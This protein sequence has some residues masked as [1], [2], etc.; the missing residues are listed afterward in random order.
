M[1]S[2]AEKF[3][4]ESQRLQNEVYQNNRDTLRKLGPLIGKS[5]A[6][7]GILHTFGSGHSEIISREIIGRAGG[8]VCIGGIPDPTAGA[9]ENLPGYGEAIAIRYARHFGM[10]KGE[11][12]IV[13]SNSGKNC[14]PIEV[15]LESKKRGLSVVAVTCLEMARQVQTQHPSGKKLHEVADFTLDN[16]GVSGDA[17]IPVPGADVKAG[18]TSTLGGALLMNLLHMEIVDY[19]ATEKQPLPLLQ[20]QNT[21]GGMERNLELARKYNKRLSKPL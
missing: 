1:S 16:G 9:V 11:F 7:G 6:A 18:P 17:M 8:L 21:E 14:S 12:I 19:L 4:T 3:F 10:E 5:I 15:A 2:L 13:I 20:S